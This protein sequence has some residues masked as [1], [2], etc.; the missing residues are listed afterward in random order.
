MLRR[1]YLLFNG[2]RTVA[3]VSLLGGMV[4]LCTVQ[5]VLRYAISTS[6]KP[7]AWGDEI[8]RL[9]SIWVVFLAASLGVREG[10]HLSVEFFLNKWLPKRAIAV[11]KKIANVIVLACMAGLIWFGIEQ[12]R[13]NLD[14]SL[15][16]LDISMG[17]FYAAIPVGCAYLF[18]DYLLITIYGY[19][20]FA[21]GFFGDGGADAEHKPEQENIR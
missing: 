1:I 9:T 10:S 6:I 3:I 4:L 11:V 21:A 14:S 7:F 19:H 16:N 17:L 8:I 18:F 13:L 20:P 2:L 12:T 15:Q 5:V